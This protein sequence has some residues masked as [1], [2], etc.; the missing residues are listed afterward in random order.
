MEL[1]K[2]LYLDMDGV[3]ANFDKEV[4]KHVDEMPWLSIPNFFRYLEPMEERI[5]LI[6]KDLQK[7]Y[8]VKILSK[9]EMRD[10][11]QRVNDKKAWVNFFLP[12]ID[13]KNIIIVPMEGNKV[14]YVARDFKNCILVDDYGVN[15]AEWKKMG[16]IAVKFGNTKKSEYYYLTS[17]KELLK[18][19]FL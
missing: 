17:L 16:G 7:K 13:N 15:L 18:P 2:T 19:D 14:D 5:D 11:E 1:K 4:K 10:H 12:S 6:V 3:L 9:V 8:D